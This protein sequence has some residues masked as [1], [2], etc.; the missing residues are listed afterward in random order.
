MRGYECLQASI[1][2]REEKKT[3]VLWEEKIRKTVGEED[4]VTGL[5][6]AYRASLRTHD[7]ERGGGGGG[8]GGGRAFSRWH[9]AARVHGRR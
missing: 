9:T 5:V 7:N 3:V 4:R 2:T 1:P 8:G 6:P